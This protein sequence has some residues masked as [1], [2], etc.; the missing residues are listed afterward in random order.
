MPDGFGTEVERDDL[1]QLVSDFESAPMPAAEGETMKTSVI[2]VR[3]MLSVLGV[4]ELEKRVGEVPGV[5]SATVDF[6]AGSVTVRYDETRI[7]ATD[8]KSAVR[9]RGYEA[10]APGGAAEA[11][12][13]ANHTGSGAPAVHV[14][15]AA[16]PPAGTPATA[17]AALASSAEQPKAAPSATS[18]ASAAAPPAPTSAAPK[19]PPAAPAVAPASPAP[20]AG[21][22]HDGKSAPDKH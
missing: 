2:E 17:G 4:D 15:A 8:I 13:H 5:E 9:Q 18:K 21:H 19:S 6:A 1:L 3:D 7:E 12:D 20:H 16:K 10:A 14:P 22:E 11:H